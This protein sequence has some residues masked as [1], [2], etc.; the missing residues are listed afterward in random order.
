MIPFL[1]GG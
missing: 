1:G